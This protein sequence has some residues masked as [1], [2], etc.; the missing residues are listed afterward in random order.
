MAIL[1]GNKDFFGID[2]GTTFVRVVQLDHGS[3]GASLRAYGAAPISHKLAHSD[4]QSDRAE[5]AQVIRKLLDDSKISAK[6]VVT[7]LSTNAIYTSI[8]EFPDLTSSEMDKAIRYQAEQYIPVS[9]DDVKLDWVEIGKTEQGQKQI[10]LVAGQKKASE[11]L[12]NM[13]ES[14]E[15]DVEVVEPDPIALTRSLLPLTYGNAALILDMGANAT[16]LVV[17][18]GGA[19]HLIR[20]IPVG[21]NAL[22]KSAIQ[23]LG[24][25]EAQAK[26]FVFKF[27]MTK[28]KLEGQVFKALQSTVDSLI[29]EVQKSVKFFLAKNP[30]Q[31]VEKIILTGGASSLPQFPLYLANNA[32]LMVEIGNT[33]TNVTYSPNMT[34]TL[35]GISSQFAVATGLALRKDF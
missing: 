6:T 19:P 27:G 28:D 5:L 20:S 8:A 29:T 31:Q 3:S 25:D 13:L 26:D 9:V 10:L 1:G 23:N 21:G 18:Y 4:S 11:N 22:V 32:G 2:I 15:L 7:G 33:W 30:N 17:V 12:L 16:D 35:N 24:V 34:D 14:I